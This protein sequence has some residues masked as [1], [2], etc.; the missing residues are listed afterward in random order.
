MVGRKLAAMAAVVAL[1]GCDLRYALGFPEP[2]VAV[3]GAGPVE[4]AYR[5][6]KGGLVIVSGRVN[7]KADVDFILD[8]GAPVTVLLDGPRTAALALDSS[9]A[10]PLGDSDDPAS[11]VGDIQGGFGIEFGPLAFSQL[12]A[13][14][15]PQRS[16][17][18]PE[19]F[20][21][22]G[23]G[24]VIGADLF[25][26]FVVEI[27]PAARRVRMHDP[28]TWSPPAGAA[29]LPL[30]FRAGHPFV[31]TRVTLADGR[32]VDMRA[33]VD[34]GMNRS[35]TLVAGSHEA[36]EMPKDGPLRKSCFVNGVREERE[37][38]AVTVGLGGLVL[39]VAK[40]IYSTSANPVA[41]RGASTIGAGLFRERRLFID[42]PGSRLLV[43]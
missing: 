31:D 37:G 15:V 33:N 27:D 17:P 26:R 16:L 38:P 41:G 25:R 34:T 40:P 42:Y 28:R 36:L 39:P 32:T 5:E 29:S 19:R 13:V 9:R 10:R 6:A 43:L 8:T 30:S 11:P 12:T 24:G 2:Q 14:V 4:L 1:A 21:E 18:C 3:A 22:V 7:G 20:E 23:F 35:L